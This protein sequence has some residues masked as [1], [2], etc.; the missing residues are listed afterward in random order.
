MRIFE[1]NILQAET[2]FFQKAVEVA[3]LAELK[4]N[5]P[6]GSVITLND[7]II[8]IGENKI[9]DSDNSCIK[10]A[11][12]NSITNIP[13]GMLHLIRD[14][15]IYSTLEPCLMCFGAISLC[16]FKKVV[17]GTYDV[18]GGFS[19]VKDFPVFF[20]ESLKK[21]VIKGNVL[22]EISRELY[23]KSLHMIGLDKDKI[24]ELME[25]HSIKASMHKV[26]KM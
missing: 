25:K 21:M 6:I 12:I 13:K 23:L 1:S 9:L 19:E 17:F 18:Y 10:H 14:M 2:K 16:G 26:K 4:G 24:S 11:E 22:P 20:E 8:S 3:K 5:L 7:E 15:T